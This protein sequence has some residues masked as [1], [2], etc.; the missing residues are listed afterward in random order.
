[1]VIF[2]TACTGLYF[3]RGLEMTKSNT[4]NQLKVVA[5]QGHYPFGDAMS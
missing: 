5:A 3:C 4:D 1:M 2:R